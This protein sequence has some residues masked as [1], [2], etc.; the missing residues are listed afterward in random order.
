MID[1]RRSLPPHLPDLHA[2]LAAALR[3]LAD[4]RDLGLLMRQSIGR[5]CEDDRAAGAQ[6]LRGRF[7]QRIEP[8]RIAV[9]NGTQNALLVLLK[10][11]VGAGGWLLAERV[12]Y[13]SL[14]AL[15]RLA[16]VQVR[17]VEIDDEGIVPDAFEAACRIQRPKALYCNP[18]V[19]NPTA[20]IMSESR[21]LEIADIAR[22]HGVAIIEDD[23]LGRLHLNAPKPI[24][25]LAPDVTW[26][27]MGMTKCM[28]QGLRIAYLVAP[29]A[30][31]LQRSIA[32]VE[33]LSY[34]HCA[35]LVGALVSHWVANGV[36]NAVS[37]RIAQ[38]CVAR[39]RLA[40]EILADLEVRSTPGSMHIWLELPASC[41]NTELV[42]AAEAEQVLLRSSELFAVD[43]QPVPNA[44][45]LSLS[46]PA[47]LDEVRRGLRIVRALVLE[48]L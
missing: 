18:T 15:A 46:P 28:A 8:S 11:L 40:R 32:P 21:R 5:G 22:R 7:E 37:S 47:N 23:A 42:V 24:A 1:F 25:A 17:G 31:R 3:S 33:H 35:P 6:L 27:V 9:A 38:E 45:R 10:M 26:Y 12:S 39:E 41:R 48:R 2:D 34:W 43:D 4:S 19:Q 36:A 16:D 20:S 29:S 14:R 13:G 30:D 44:V